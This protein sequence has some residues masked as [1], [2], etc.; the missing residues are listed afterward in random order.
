MSSHHNSTINFTHAP[1]KKS[2]SLKDI[3]REIKMGEL[4]LRYIPPL[5]DAHMML[6][7]KNA[8]KLIKESESI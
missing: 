5:R 4:R 6:G 2:D 3:D 1:F 8:N 7:C